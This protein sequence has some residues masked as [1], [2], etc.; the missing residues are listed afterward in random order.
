MASHGVLGVD[1][2]IVNLATDSDGERYTGEPTRA[3]RERIAALRADLQAAGTKSAKR[4]LKELAGK[5]ARF[6][7]D[8]NHCISKKLVAKA[9]GTGA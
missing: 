4:H 5:E 3:V 9:Q 2:G 8:T 7:A 6:H 1:L